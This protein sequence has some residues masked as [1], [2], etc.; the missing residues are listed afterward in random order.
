MERPRGGGAA[1]TSFDTVVYCPFML[2]AI[3]LVVAMVCVASPVATVACEAMCAASEARSPATHHACHQHPA[4]EQGAA[5]AAVHVCGHEDGAPSAIQRAVTSG[6][7]LPAV[8]S[9][10]TVVEQIVDTEYGSAQALDPSPP[11]PLTSISQL[12]V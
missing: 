8:V 3:A 5:V 10:V 11:T 6:L 7:D 12:R 9:S 1:V 4:A 2:R